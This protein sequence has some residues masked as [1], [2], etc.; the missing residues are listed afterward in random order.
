M[1]EPNFEHLFYEDISHVFV[2]GEYP[3]AWIWGMDVGNRPWIL[4]LYAVKLNYI[5]VSRDLKDQ[6]AQIE[7]DGKANEMIRILNK[8][9]HR[10]KMINTL[11]DMEYKSAMDREYGDDYDYIYDEEYEQITQVLK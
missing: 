10:A 7:T 1:K 9:A 11:L 3:N 4:A 2:G 5:F 8:R 6:K